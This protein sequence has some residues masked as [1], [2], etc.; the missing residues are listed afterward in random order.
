MLPREK[1]V[2]KLGVGSTVSED[3]DVGRLASGNLYSN[4]FYSSLLNGR[5]V[6]HLYCCVTYSLPWW[7]VTV[8]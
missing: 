8:S 3:I 4:L 5:I 2:A 6:M 1:A 7:P